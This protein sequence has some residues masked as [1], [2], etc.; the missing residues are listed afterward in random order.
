M[1]ID[2]LSN[3]KSDLDAFIA[4]DETVTPADL[5][6]WIGNFLDSVAVGG[7]IS[8]GRGFGNDPAPTELSASLASTTK[9]GGW[10]AA[11]EARGVAC[12]FANGR[13]TILA[14]GEGHYDVDW[15][16]DFQGV[17][18]RRYLFAVKVSRAAVNGGTPAIEMDSI[19]EDGIVASGQV[20]HVGSNPRIINLA[21][22]DWIELHGIANGASN[23]FVPRQGRLRIK[24][25]DAAD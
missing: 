22:G 25:V 1:A 23:A 10:T 4:N 13:L 18:G 5:Q 7:G 19:S 14:G 3:I 24:R 2:A 21:A 9:I 17:S 8:Q 6:R 16:L 20:G 15:G 11:M 12:D